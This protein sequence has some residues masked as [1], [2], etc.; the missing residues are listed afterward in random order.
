L[1]AVEAIL[2]RR[3]VREYTGIVVPDDVVRELLHA[4]MSAPSSKGS[5]PWH[6]LVINDRK[7][8]NRIPLYFPYAFMIRRAPVAII[9]CGDESKT[10]YGVYWTFDCAAA[11]ENILIAAH[12][13]GLG[14]VWC[15]AYKAETPQETSFQDWLGIPKNVVPFAVVPIGYPVKHNHEILER[16]DSSIVHVNRW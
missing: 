8:L 2:S 15:G 6:F 14:A 1:E 13:R 7:T 16:F 11:T 5:K 9:I 12:A 10:A 4:A 3:S